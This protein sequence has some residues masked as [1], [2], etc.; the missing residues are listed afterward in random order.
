MYDGGNYTPKNGI[1]EETHGPKVDGQA[2]STK[3][4]RPIVRVIVGQLSD[5]KQ[6]NW[7]K[8]GQAKG[9]C[10]DGYQCREC[11]LRTQVDEREDD[12]DGGYQTEYLQRNL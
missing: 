9:R 4:E 6:R 12:Q 3:P 5:N 10:R 1:Y 11:N 8:I 7:E 2:P